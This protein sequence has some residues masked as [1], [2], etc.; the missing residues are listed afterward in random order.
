M[1]FTTRLTDSPAIVTSQ[2]SPHLRKMMKTMM[3]GQGDGA[4]M[5][6][7]LEVNPKHHLITTLAS[8]KETNTPV[9]RVAA[10]QLYDTAT[11][12]AGMVDE[13]KVLLP[14]LN[15][16]LEV[17]LYQGAGFDYRTGTYAT[18]TGAADSKFEE[19]AADGATEATATEK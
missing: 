3:Q 19:A 7:T 8:V 17:C 14:R 6:C 10:Q 5:P 4:A 12:A 18:A 13:P 16:L 9:A 2:L 1:K 11:I 15:K